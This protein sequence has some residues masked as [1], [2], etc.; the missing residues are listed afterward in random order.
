MIA[1]SSRKAVIFSKKKRGY[2]NL[3]ALEVSP[4][5]HENK[6]VQPTHSVS[7]VLLITFSF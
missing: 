6:K 3:S 2:C 7:V 1:T 5:T 4:N